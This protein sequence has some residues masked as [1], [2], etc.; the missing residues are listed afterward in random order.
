MG[1]W[2]K[3]FRRPY[4]KELYRGRR[5]GKWTN[6]DQYEEDTPSNPA[7]LRKIVE[8]AVV[9]SDRLQ[10]AV[11]EV[12]SSMGQLESV[13]DQS[14]EHEER[15]RDNGRYAIARL[16]E[17]FSA[18]QE[19]A[20]ASEQIRGASG[21]LREQSRKTKD[22]VVDVCRSLQDTDDAM[23]ELSAHHGAM[24]ERVN[25]LIVQS[26]KISEIN[27]LIQNIVAQTSLLAINAAIEAAHAGD[28]GR[29]FG[30]VAAEIRQLADQSG[31]AVKRSTSI[32]QSIESG[33]REVVSSV[34]LEKRSV[35]RS[36]EEMG[37]N[38]DRMDVIFNQIVK[39][40][41]HVEQT[42][43][44]SIEQAERTGATNERL[45]LVVNSVGITM[46]SVDQ[47]LVNN[48]KQRAEIA[49]LGRVSEEMKDVAGELTA[50]VQ[51][52]GER[53]W[54]NVVKM[55]AGKWVDLLR[56]LTSDLA[57]GG[58]DENVHREVLGAWMARSPGM[59]AVWSN[60]SDG[61]FVFSEPEAG[62][63]NARSREWWKRAMDG[64]TYVSE[65]YISAITKRPCMTVSMPLRGADGVSLGVVG[66]D[67]V[68]S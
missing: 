68:V 66:I 37:K 9:I 11:T 51:L 54:E 18:L 27:A 5:S 7:A 21:Q 39:V 22:V 33:I 23:S 17:A 41:G 1:N 32:V 47:L 6:T 34:E 12:D 24:E 55:D 58:L 67:I 52:A 64:E 19:A 31:E 48:K 44:S 36:L 62:L 35:A 28:R 43:Q 3:W 16:D 26:L 65:I 38:R 50:A 13:A 45:R 61:S 59:E 4:S 60:R 56:S 10:A 63:L 57:Q 53:G 29:G 25:A 30:V 46:E 8:N 42:L 15:L 20:A 40:D 2:R 14:A 49:N